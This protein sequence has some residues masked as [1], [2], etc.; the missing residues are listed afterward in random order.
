M[1]CRTLASSPVHDQTIIITTACLPPRQDNILW[2]NHHIIMKKEMKFHNA[3]EHQRPD[4][5]WVSGC[6]AHRGDDRWARVNLVRGRESFAECN[7]R[8]DGVGGLGNA[9]RTHKW[10][11]VKR[12]QKW[13]MKLLWKPKRRREFLPSLEIASVKFRWDLT[14]YLPIYFKLFVR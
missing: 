1:L 13:W 7:S 2:Y 11:M 8:D 5:D 6:R 10:I 4:M 14:T 9:I 12:K 3:T